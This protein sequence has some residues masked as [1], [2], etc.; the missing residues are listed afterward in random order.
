VGQNFYPV[1]NNN[2]VA[3]GTGH[4]HC[5][6]GTATRNTLTKSSTCSS[7]YTQRMTPGCTITSRCT[8]RWSGVRPTLLFDVA[9]PVARRIRVLSFSPQSHGSG[10]HGR[11]VS[12]VRPLAQKPALEMK[13]R[14][15]DSFD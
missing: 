1:T 4:P 11:S 8:C 13:I 14:L 2:S 15:P 10:E 3:T 12:L 6:H 7:W 5:T 9:I